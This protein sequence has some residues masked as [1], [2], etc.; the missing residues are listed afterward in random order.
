MK[1]TRKL[2]KHTLITGS[3]IALLGL[4]FLTS[5]AQADDTDYCHV[6]YDIINEWGTGFQVDVTLTNKTLEPISG[7]E[8]VWSMSESFDSGWNASYS[9]EGTTFT[10]SNDATQWN[11]TIAADYGQ[12]SF[13]FNATYG[14]SPATVISGFVLNGNICSSGDTV[15]SSS[16]SSDSSSSSSSTSSSSSSTSS[17]SSST[18]STTGEGDCADVNEYPNWTAKDW[19]G[20]VSNHADTGDQMVYLGN[21]YRANWYTNSVPGSDASWT[22]LGSCDESTTSSSTS[23]TSSTTTSSSTS[24]TSSSTSSMSSSSGSTSSTASSTSSSGSTSSTPQ[25]GTL[26]AGDYDDV[27]NP[28]LYSSYVSDYL[29]S[30][31]G[32]TLPFLNMNEALTV[33]V[34]DSDGTPFPHAKLVVNESDTALLTHYTAANGQTILYPSIDGLP[35]VFD[36]TAS[37]ASDDVLISQTVDLSALGD[38]RSLEFTLPLLSPGP[39][40]KLDLLLVIDTTGSMS[41]ELNYLQAELTSILSAISED[42]PAVNIRVGLIVYRD[43]GDSYVTREF[44]LTDDI[45]TIQDDLNAQIASGGGNYPEAMDEALELA[46]QAE[47]RSDAV[48]AL[49]LVADAPPHD[50]N[51]MATWNSVLTARENQIHIAPVAASG[52]GDVAEFL[53]RS[54]AAVTQSRYLFLTDDSGVGGSH[55]EPSV[56]CYIVTRLD[57]LVRRVVSSLLIGERVEPSEEEII[58]TV[59]NYNAGVCEPIVEPTAEPTTEPTAEPT[60]E[61]TAEPTTEPTAEPTTE[62]TAEPSAEPVEL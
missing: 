61:P 8:L 9:S 33:T 43:T 4:G 18:S 56:D 49:L 11:G 62:P 50:E 44:P 41:D 12:V 15:S 57:N 59:G 47:W 26:T 35:D 3:R 34:L 54:A 25:A 5:I 27:L 42:N 31:A 60:T 37:N 19:E 10:A 17:T 46:M 36:I 28:H 48:K 53:M 24:S 55:Q 29:Q 7:Y 2:L 20:G 40:D 45:A 6:D 1:K 16:S 14:S 22:L 32:T 58:R 39:V 30:H 23:S 52:V 38:D 21:L 13:G 51:I